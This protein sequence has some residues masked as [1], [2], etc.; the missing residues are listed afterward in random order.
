MDPKDSALYDYV[1]FSDG[2][3]HQD[4]Y[5]GWCAVVINQHDG[6][7]M[8]TLGS[9][10]PSSTNRAEFTALLE[11]LELIQT[12]ID[13]GKLKSIHPGRPRIHWY[14]DRESLVG[15]VS[16]KWGEFAG[17]SAEPDLWRRFE[18]YE[19]RFVITATHIKRETDF[20]DFEFADLHA[21]SQRIVLKSYCE[22]NL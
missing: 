1:L 11:G 8:R 2:S 14:S 7:V 21:S 22:D 6:S 9:V 10:F 19:N 3:G 12:L 20:A 4:G 5:S 18:H 17:R 15:S 13:N 16:R